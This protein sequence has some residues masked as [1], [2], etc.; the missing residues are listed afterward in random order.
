[1]ISPKYYV[2]ASNLVREIVFDDGVVWIALFARLDSEGLFSAQE[3]LMKRLRSSMAVPEVY[4][5]SDKTE[6]LGARY[7]IIEGICGRRAEAQYLMF[8]VPDRHW[9]TLLDQLGKVLA[10]GMK[11]TWKEFDIADK[12]YVSDSSFWIDPAEKNIL[13]ALKQLNDQRHLFDFG[14][15][16]KFIQST[17]PVIDL[18]FSES[19]YLCCHLLK[20]S[21]RPVD[22]R[23]RFPSHLPSLSMQNLIFDDEYNI[24]GIIGFPRTQ[25]VSSW[26]YFQLPLGLEEDFENTSTQKTE[27]WMR[28]EFVRSW[29]QNISRTGV[30]WEGL[31]QWL[32][33]CKKDSVQLLRRFRTAKPSPVSLEQFFE[34]MYSFGSDVPLEMVK[35][36]HLFTTVALLIHYPVA[37]EAEK[38][39]FHVDMFSRMLGM[40]GKGL[41]QIGGAGRSLREGKFD[42]Q[43]LHLP[44]FAEPHVSPQ[45]EPKENQEV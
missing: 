15:W 2:G 10:A 35:D 13:R 1:M 23:G 38:C 25:G 37:W 22:S 43:N 19:L 30:P 14:H 8:G 36:A 41:G 26:E 7:I 42:L 3:K 40:D 5:C 24:K 34:K 39:E 44:R 20:P 18:L 12:K 9:H 28:M 21:H 31:D 17:L 6:E 33:W 27:D 45:S 16:S 4:A 11:V 29:R 32:P